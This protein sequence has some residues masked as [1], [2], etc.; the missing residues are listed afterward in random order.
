[1]SFVESC[2]PWWAGSSRS[3]FQI[4]LPK[5]RQDNQYFGIGKAAKTELSV[6]LECCEILVGTP[7]KNMCAI[8]M[9]KFM[10][11]DPFTTFTGAGM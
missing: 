7:A 11:F 6:W 3:K 1:M 8:E 5:R 9:Q 10:E 4:D 2:R